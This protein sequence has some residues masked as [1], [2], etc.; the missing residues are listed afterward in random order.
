MW[1]LSVKISFSVIM[2]SHGNKAFQYLCKNLSRNLLPFCLTTG[3][4]C[5]VIPNFFFK[6]WKLE[7]HI[8]IKVILKS[9]KLSVSWLTSSYYNYYYYQYNI[10]ILLILRST[11]YLWLSLC[12]THVF[13]LAHVRYDIR[14]T[15]GCNGPSSKTFTAQYFQHFEAAQIMCTF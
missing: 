5:D 13:I 6:F 14:S 9:N 15:L 8:K 11:S 12:I 4:L 1:V 10:L 2:A 7:Y 3:N